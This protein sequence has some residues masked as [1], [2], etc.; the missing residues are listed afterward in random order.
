[1]HTGIMEVNT[2]CAS[3]FPA[4]VP[5]HHLWPGEGCTHGADVA[6]DAFPTHTDGPDRPWHSTGTAAG[7]HTTRKRERG[8]ENRTFMAFFFC[9]FY[10][11]A[12]KNTCLLFVCFLFFPLSL[13]TTSLWTYLKYKRQHAASQEQTQ[14]HCN[15]VQLACWMGL[16]RDM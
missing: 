1:M 13:L 8:E 4:D 6:A 10:A 12:L 3:L 15:E 11:S 9:F 2:F 7:C 16:E 5:C 14:L